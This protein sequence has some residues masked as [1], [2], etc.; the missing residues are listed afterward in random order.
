MEFRKSAD[1]LK[2]AANAIV[3][4]KEHER[5]SNVQGGHP[6]RPPRH[7]KHN[8]QSVSQKSMSKQPNIGRES[9]DALLSPNEVKFTPETN[10]EGTMSYKGAGLQCNVM[11][12]TCTLYSI[13]KHLL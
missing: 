5:H 9:S 7:N 11:N 1:A 13:S 10:H 12:K 8:Y 4:D 6:Q 3:G 2:D